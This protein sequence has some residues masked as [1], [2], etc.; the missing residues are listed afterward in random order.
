MQTNEECLTRVIQLFNLLY[1]KSF[2]HIID[3]EN[4]F[5][6]VGDEMLDVAN[7][8]RENV[9]GRTWYDVMSP[10]PDNIVS[11]ELGIRAA[12]STRLAQHAITINVKRHETTQ[13]ILHVIQKPII[14]PAT[15]QVVAVHI[16]FFKVN[17]PLYFHHLLLKN[18]ERITTRCLTYEQ[19]GI[20]TRREHE[21]AF[22]LFY[23]KSL[24]DIVEVINAHSDRKITAKTIRNIISQ[25]LFKKLH[26]FNR[27]S[28]LEELHKLEYHRKIP[29]SL[30][31][32]PHID[33][34][35]L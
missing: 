13:R 35:E 7:E 21:I 34:S 18:P 10:H 2:I 27:D 12:I 25:Q 26:V 1:R 6:F 8:T 23:C 30:L 9:I 4:R 28:L 5:I 3:L 33:I 17:F 16:E 14:N 20:L 29:S 31:S 32:N 19:E 22:L 15:D 24:D 11:T